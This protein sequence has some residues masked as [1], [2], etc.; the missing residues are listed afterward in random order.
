MWEFELG[1]GL[2]RAR[3]VCPLGFV[4]VV[5]FYF[6]G[7]AIGLGGDFRLRHD[8]A[9][10]RDGGGGEIVDEDEEER[11]NDAVLCGGV[12]YMP[13]KAEEPGYGSEWY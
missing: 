3:A 2:G 1:V 7:G 9:E 12:V 5:P 4:V 8:G 10:R 11:G 6:L 13:G